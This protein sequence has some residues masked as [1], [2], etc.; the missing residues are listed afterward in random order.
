MLGLSRDP[1]RVYD[2]DQC[3]WSA[4][5][6]WLGS[7]LDRDIV[8]DLVPGAICDLLRER[9]HIL[10]LRRVELFPCSVRN[11]DLRAILRHVIPPAA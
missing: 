7:H 3:Y 1:R 11:L 5:D 8:W 9:F 4:G 10:F 2:S 6:I